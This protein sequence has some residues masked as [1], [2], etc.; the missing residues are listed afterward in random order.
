MYLAKLPLHPSM[1]PLT[2]EMLLKDTSTGC[3]DPPPF[4]EFR[5]TNHLLRWKFNLSVIFH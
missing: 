1:V 5:L 4:A 2:P 3:Y